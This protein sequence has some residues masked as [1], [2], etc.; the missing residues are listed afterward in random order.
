ME[1]SHITG[2]SQK[3][4][5]TKKQG[6]L[7]YREYDPVQPASWISW[8]HLSLK[9]QRRYMRC[10]RPLLVSRLHI[11]RYPTY[12][13]TFSDARKKDAQATAGDDTPLA[14]GSRI[15][16]PSAL[17]LLI[18]SS[19]TIRIGHTQL[20]GML[21]V[22]L[23]S[24]SSILSVVYQVI[25]GYATWAC[26]KR[27]PK[28]CQVNPQQCHW[29]PHVILP[30]TRG[31]PAVLRYPM[32]TRGWGPPRLRHQRFDIQKTN[33]VVDSMDRRPTKTSIYR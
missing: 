6:I 11:P 25:S 24:S 18:G 2:T 9:L 20:L 21:C 32:G 15:K 23:E 13:T 26:H 1:A 29:V 19:T 5:I 17:D 31:D 16:D 14:Q 33:R 30:R 28:M 7:R 12:I 27:G 10:L 22:D 4:R 8:M 3:L